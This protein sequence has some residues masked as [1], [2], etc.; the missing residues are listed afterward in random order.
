MSLARRLKRLEGRLDERGRLLCSCTDA[1]ALRIVW[2]E[3]ESEPEPEV[4]DETCN[5]CGGVR[6]PLLIQVVYDDPPRSENAPGEPGAE[7]DDL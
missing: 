7:W 4:R 3:D 6:K 5:R 1:P 2:P